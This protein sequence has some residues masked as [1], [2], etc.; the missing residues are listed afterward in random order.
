MW[1]MVYSYLPDWKVFLQ[2][3]IAFFVPFAIS[4]FFKWARTLEEE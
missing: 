2:G 3:F 4:R 1:K